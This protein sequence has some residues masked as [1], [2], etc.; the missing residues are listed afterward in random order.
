[1]GGGMEKRVAQNLGELLSAANDHRD[2][3]IS[4]RWPL[5][6]GRLS[7]FHQWADD[8][9]TIGAY[10]L[11]PPQRQPFWIVLL[12]WKRTGD[13]YCS[14]FPS[15]R[16]GPLA[17]IHKQLDAPNGT[18]LSWKYSPTLRDGQNERR[19]TY[20]EQTFGSRDVLL[21]LPVGTD[22]IDTFIEDIAYLIEC[23]IKADALAE[24]LPS[25]SDGFPEGRLVERRHIARER[26]SAV[27]ELAKDLALKRFGYLRCA[28]CGFD[29]ERAYG[30][31]GKGYIEA[32]HTK[33]LSELAEETITTVEDLALVCSNCHRM[34]H[35]RRPW[36]RGDQLKDLLA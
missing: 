2:S 14:L 25:S 21:Q 30:T 8:R 32:H 6:N 16:H 33:P 17:E 36:L 15:S 35:R 28:C 29:F 31:L 7:A 1:M 3:F 26:K 24:Q 27:T 4:E 9:P 22:E 10:L 12:D 18:F 23:R 34:L 11:S 5:K 20:F 19:R 13:Y